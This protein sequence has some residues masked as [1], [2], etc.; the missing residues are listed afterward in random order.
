MNVARPES[1][2]TA[3]GLES[4]AS[5]SAKSCTQLTP[6][7]SF[8]APR[9]VERASGMTDPQIDSGGRVDVPRGVVHRLAK[10]Q[11]DELIIVEA[12]SGP[13]RAKTTSSD[14]PMTTAGDERGGRA[15][16]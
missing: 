16:R 5:V 12:S 15:V 7:R 11:D 3:R 6:E 10:E 4:A 9:W 13:T 1:I 8:P 14:W 2:T